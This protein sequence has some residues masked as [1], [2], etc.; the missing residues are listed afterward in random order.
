MLDPCRRPASA[1]P[2]PRPAL[3]LILIAVI[4]A[5]TAA[6]TTT[7]VPAFAAAPP[8]SA[9]DLSAALPAARAV[10][11]DAPVVIVKAPDLASDAELVRFDAELLP[12]LLRVRT[13]DHVRIAGWPV[14]PGT[15]RD[16]VIVRHEIYAPGARVLRVDAGGT[17]E[18]PRSRLVFFWGS[19][20]D[21]PSSGIYVAVDP[22][23]GTVESLIRT[24]AGGQH[25][26]RPLVP[27][28]PGLHLLATP[29]AFLAGQGSHPQPAWSCG[30][31]QLG[32]AAAGAHS[33]AAPIAHGSPAAGLGLRPPLLS[34]PA[35]AEP[36]A[37]LP[38][39]AEISGPITASAGFNF[40]TVAIDT[41][42]EFMSQKF[43]DD[44][45]AATN[46]IASLFAQINVMYERDL[47]VQLLVGTAILR[48]AS[49]TDP[50]M[51]QPNT[52]GAASSAELTEFSNYWAANEG[53][54]TRTVTSMLSGKSPSAYSASG[55]AWVG[56]LCDHGYGYNFSQVFLIDYLAGDA[57]IVGHEIG[58]NFGSVHTHCYS[59]PIDECWNVEPGCY[60]GP[61]VCPAPTT[62]NGVP[63]VYGTIMGYCHLLSGCQTDMVFHPRTVAVINPH[64]GSALGVCMTQGNV[65]APAVSAIHPD[66]G[67]TAG[68]TAVVISG[69][70]FQSG[71]AV[72]IGGVAAT[73]VNVTGPGTIT[74]VTG[75]HVTGLVDVVV[76]G[77][78]GAGT[79]A[80]SFFYSPPLGPAGFFTV[81]PCR[82]VDTRNAVGPLGGPAL[83]A[84]QTRSFTIAGT[85]GIPG[86]AVA[87][88]ANLTVISS[89]AGF[90]SL[91]PGNAL[92]LGTSNL[93]FGA[94][95]TRAN[96]SVL[97][98]ATD[99]TGTVGVL[100]SST[101]GTNFLID[102]NG[103]FQ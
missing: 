47:Q 92:P 45:T 27:G 12:A 103:Y 52:G 28:K 25:Q 43:S 5:L 97:M 49:V 101:T 36:A 100:N 15:R 58:H 91:F 44:T 88:S 63:N 8:T 65:A 30:E 31:D 42:H 51:Q 37:P 69:S 17:H 1:G 50:Y 77:G 46:Y 61:Q 14:A 102:V 82:V 48:T 72:T 62:I 90:L 94:G 34:L 71:D 22:V 6:V 13:G 4:V 39:V 66:V 83:S 18:I 16:V 3:S 89:A 32:G 54:V 33:A 9:F 26:L 84:T 70:N 74:A 20:A 38:T 78:G 86:S 40:A 75:A 55:I 24:A 41:D 96:N 19:L 81:P 95:Q 35:P 79:L 10:P 80:R 56:S 87:V 23:T 7:S 21:D 76:S 99:G 60:S 98:L 73:G 11:P 53:T 57:L 64:I 93:N 29:E 59:P 68:G 2:H 67:P 85:C